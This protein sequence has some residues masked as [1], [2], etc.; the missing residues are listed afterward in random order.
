MAS[1]YSAGNLSAALL[2]LKC[3]MAAIAGVDPSTISLVSGA[4]LAPAL[5]G[6]ALAAAQAEASAATNATCAALASRQAAIDNSTATGYRR[7]RALTA[8]SGACP[9]VT[10][11]TTTVPLLSVGVQLGVGTSAGAV[12]LAAAR[13]AAAPASAYNLTTAVWSTINCAVFASNPFTVAGI[14]PVNGDGGGGG[15]GSASGLT[16]SQQLGLGLGIALSLAA[17]VALILNCHYCPRSVCACC[18]CCAGGG[19]RRAADD[20]RRED[21]GAAGA[22]PGPLAPGAVAVGIDKPAPASTAS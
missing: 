21:A 22:A 14:T 15:G 11:A 19:R 17:I 18:G 4:A 16:T 6:A 8:T 2:A 12:T 9:S 20:R 5:S 1:S 13:L 3:D 7:R 10:T